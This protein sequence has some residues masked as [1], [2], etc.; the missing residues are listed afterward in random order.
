MELITEPAL[1]GSTISFVRLV[2]G[3]SG[4]AEQSLLDGR[5]TRRLNCPTNYTTP[6]A[7]QWLIRPA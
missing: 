3:G 1:A 2:I 7:Y 6:A 4:P 5:R